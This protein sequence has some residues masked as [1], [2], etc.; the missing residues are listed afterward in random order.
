MDDKLKQ[1][2]TGSEP[3]G[4]DGLENK[5]RHW[6]FFAGIVLVALMISAYSMY[7]IL[8]TVKNSS[9]SKKSAT[10]FPSAQNLVD[11]A[12]I[13]LKGK[14]QDITI[15]DGMG[16]RTSTG[17]WA[18]GLP[19]LQPSGKKF[20]A[21]PASGAGAGYISDSETAKRNYQA[22]ES[23][24]NKNNFTF[25][26]SSRDQTGPISDNKDI[27]TYD[28]YGIYE[29]NQIRCAI[30]DAD[31][32][33]TTVKNYV[34]GIGCADKS[35][36]TDAANALQPFYDAYV[37]GTK[38]SVNN[39]VLGVPTL[40]KGADG[41]QYAIVYQENKSEFSGSFQGLYY[42]EP[43]KDWTIFTVTQGVPFCSSYDTSVLKKAFA[44]IKC[45]DNVRKVNSTL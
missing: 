11:Q 39:V 44:G 17:F 18:Y 22:L 43:G 31:A 16:G 12:R 45:Y 24:F 33:Q 37:A 6:L 23:F 29:S 9:D 8:N 10:Q 14:N 20:K 26:T 28:W 36:Y 5:W 1:S 15:A 13:N 35:S 2:A 41:Y 40:A 3:T 27:V 30:F 34:V 21:F 38:K 4:H 25:V 42:M 7:G 32:T 19:T